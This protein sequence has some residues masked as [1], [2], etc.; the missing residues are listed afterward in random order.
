MI[1]KFAELEAKMSPKAIIRS[2]ERY[3]KMVAEMNLH[4]SRQA[5]E[6]SQE[7]LAEEPINREKEDTL[8]SDFLFRSRM[9]R[10]K[11]RVRRRFVG[12]PSPLV[13]NNQEK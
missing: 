8:A 13:P 10:T 11:V 12:R 7:N 2:D 6:I 5:C 4:E 9:R 1:R 3:Q